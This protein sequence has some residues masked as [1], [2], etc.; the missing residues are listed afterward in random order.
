MLLRPVTSSRRRPRMTAATVI[1]VLVVLAAAVSVAR[2]HGVGRGSCTA[3][4][5][6]GPGGAGSTTV[7][8]AF[9]QWRHEQ[10]WTTPRWG[11]RSTTSGAG[12]VTYRAGGHE[13]QLLE[14]VSGWQ[15]GSV[16]RPC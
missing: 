14:T 6:A 1:T 3:S 8:A 15:V 4:V 16:T 5:L 7:P 10:P 2:L 13:V 9:G 11:W 12:V